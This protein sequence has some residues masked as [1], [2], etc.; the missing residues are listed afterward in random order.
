MAG[1]AGGI[2]ALRDFYKCMYFCVC[3]M[4]WMCV[5]HIIYICVADVYM[6]DSCGERSV[7]G[8][9]S[10]WRADGFVRGAGDVVLGCQLQ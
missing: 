8:G 7:S 9:V 5:S 4:L 1:V 10:V 3:L 6:C 2:V